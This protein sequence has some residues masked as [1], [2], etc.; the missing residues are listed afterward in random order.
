LC[1]DEEEKAFKYG[2]MGMRDPFVPLVDKDGK[3]T[4][5]H[6][7][8]DTINDIA[9]E[10]I[11]YDSEGESVVILNGLVLNEGDQVGNIKVERIF[12]HRVILSAK[13]K[14]YTLKLKE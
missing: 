7:S 2:D 9:V 14:E 1:A 4:V 3:L 8:I 6:G 10:G 11:L 5:I 13:G 12:E